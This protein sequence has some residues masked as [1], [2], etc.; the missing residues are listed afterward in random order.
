MGLIPAGVMGHRE[1]KLVAGRDLATARRLLAEAGVASGFK[2]TLAVLNNTDSVTGA[3][4]IQANLAEVGIDVQITPYESGTFWNLG[5]EGKGNDWKTLQLY[6]QKWGL[7]PDPGGMTQW[8]TT[9]Q[10]G[11]WNWERWSDPEFDS[12]HRQALSEMDPKKREQLYKQMQ[13]RMEASGAFVWLTNGVQALMYRNW[14]EPGTT[15]DGR[16]LLV[17]EFRRAG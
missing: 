7:P 9:E 13:D 1:R 6:L 11:K 15:P 12:L 10:I 8:W 16:L 4:V 17:S 5:V 2:T 3:Q 14:I